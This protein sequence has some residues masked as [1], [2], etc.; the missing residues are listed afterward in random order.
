MTSALQRLY[1]MI[2]DQVTDYDVKQKLLAVL[3]SIAE[4]K[5]ASPRHR[6]A[7]C[8]RTFPAGTMHRATA[9]GVWICGVTED[10]EY[11][12]E[13]AGAARTARY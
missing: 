5:T 6:C 9:P 4:P 8:K 10:D 3:D 1:T 2:E 7:K 12:I 13:C 11:A